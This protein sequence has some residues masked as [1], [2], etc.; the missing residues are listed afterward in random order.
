GRFP[1]NTNNL[2]F[3]FP[4]LASI[5][6]NYINTFCVLVPLTRSCSKIGL[7]PR[8]RIYVESPLSRTTRTWGYL[9]R[10]GDQVHV[11]LVIN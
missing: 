1:R 6:N 8:C 7:V 2:W 5:R 3:F 4:D 10:A 9:S 11:S